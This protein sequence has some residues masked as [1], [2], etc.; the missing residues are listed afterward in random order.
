MIN[1]AFQLHNYSKLW[2]NIYFAGQNNSWHGSFEGVNYKET[3]YATGVFRCS[4]GFHIT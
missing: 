2:L 4:P 1:S 3:L